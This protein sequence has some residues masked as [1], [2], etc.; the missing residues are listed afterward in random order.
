MLIFPDQTDLGR[1][2]SHLAFLK[3]L[4]PEERF[5][6]RQAQRTDI[7]VEDGMD[8]LA[9]A[10]FV[11]LDDEDLLRVLGY[12]VLQGLLA[13]GRVTAIL[14]AAVQLDELP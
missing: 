1:R 12:L 4:T 10:A 8:M 6:I 13:S 2:M 11:D 7:V 5:A 14:T 3:R 9:K